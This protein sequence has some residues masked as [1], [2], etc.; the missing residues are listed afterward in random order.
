MK[1]I[2]YAPVL[3]TLFIFIFA[4][5]LPEGSKADPA[6][7]P[8]DSLI[9]S[10]VEQ[11]SFDSMYFNVCSLVDFHTRHTYSDTL[12]D[13]VGIGAARRWLLAKFLQAGADAELFPW[14]GSWRGPYPCYNVHGILT[15]GG[16]QSP[17]IV[18]GAHLD[19]R[20]YSGNDTAGFAPGA[21][22]DGSGIAA[23]LEISRIL[24]GSGRNNAVTMAG[25]AGEEQGLLG[26]HAYSQALLDSGRQVG[27]MINMDMLG[28]IVHPGGAVDSST[29]RCYSGGPMSSSSRQLAR[30]LKWV[31]ES[32]SGGLSVTLID[33]LDRPGRGGDHAPFYHRGFPAVRLIETAED[34]AYQHN[35][36]DLPEHMSFSYARKVARL[37]LGVTAVLSQTRLSAP[38][39]PQVVNAG[40]G[41]SLIVSWPDTLIP[42]PGGVIRIAYRMS[43]ELYWEDIVATSNPPP[44]TISGLVENQHY[45]VSL[46]I[47]NEDD[48]PSPFGPEAS[49][50]PQAAVAPQGFESVS[51]PSGVELRWI[52]RPE[53]NTY[54]YIIER[55]EAGGQFTAAT[56]VAHPDSFWRDSSLTIG[57]MYHYRLRTRTN[58]GIV[59]A[60]S[61]VRKGMLASHHLGIMIVDATPDGPGAP[62]APGDSEVDEFYDT[63]LN[64]Y[65]TSGRW[66]RA[67]SVA[68]N[69]ELTD[70]DLAA[71]SIVVTHMDA[72]NADIGEDTIAYGKYLEN[73][74]K[75]FICGWRMSSSI[76]G[77]AGYAHRFG[78][79]DFLYEL[80]G[81]DSIRVSTPPT[82]EFVG[83]AGLNGYPA[84]A[85]DTAR[86]P[87]WRGELPFSDAVWTDVFH[88]SVQPIAAFTSASG[89][90]SPFHGRTVGLCSDLANPQWII[91]DAPLFYMI[92]STAADFMGHAMDL[93]GAPPNAVD[94]LP[95]GAIPMEFKLYSPY[96]N[97]LNAQ[98]VLS[99][100]LPK[101]MFVSLTIYDIQGR[102]VIRLIDGFYP[103]GAHRTRFDGTGLASGIYLAQLRAADMRRTIKLLL[104][105]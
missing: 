53:P 50:T 21:D 16:G 17:I 68:S 56:T 105:K 104:I 10:Q 62:S 97:P 47:S 101:Q 37:A 44:L 93:M 80:C 78:Q 74:G 91:L 65:Q 40:N 71:Y 33:A 100:S 75:L 84:I 88:G 76:E 77:S 66:D 92:Q 26:S 29:V 31:G 5:F 2:Q 82:V 4:S 46:S 13:T 64:P 14:T 24:S 18:L 57:Q 35:P 103:G 81:I 79:G 11:V 85:L 72:M 95:R 20:T 52:P 67:D 32:Y 28:H 58:G 61:P 102:E 59:G 22:D 34:A 96:P 73:G 12:S 30:Y 54:E 9:L 51:T 41:H 98:A 48:L 63:I 55:A 89:T 99:F 1:E 70:A 7:F 36:N 19:S 45:E 8:A 69:V 49:G 94:D 15:G 39:A 87:C 90:G 3:T 42:P 83:A 86:F 6:P 23:L 25:F 27:A 38:P 43:T 60:P